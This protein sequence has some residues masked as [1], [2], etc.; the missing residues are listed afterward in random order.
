[1]LHGQR[2]WQKEYRK[3]MKCH[4]NSFF[5]Y[6]FLI[7]ERSDFYPTV[8]VKKLSGFIERNPTEKGDFILTNSQNMQ[9][10]IEKNL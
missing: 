10:L 1:M 3:R 6:P 2:P 8:K 5:S 7:A 9:L 4:L